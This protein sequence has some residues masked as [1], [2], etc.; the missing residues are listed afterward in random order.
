MLTEDLEGRRRACIAK[1]VHSTRLRSLDPLLE[2]RIW[3]LAPS[4]GV[5]TPV[6]EAGIEKAGLKPADRL[7]QC[8]DPQPYQALLSWL[9]ERVEAA[10]VPIAA[11][12]R[13]RRAAARMSGE[14]G[15]EDR[16][17]AER[18][19]FRRVRTW[20]GDF[21]RVGQRSQVGLPHVD[22]VRLARGR[23]GRSLLQRWRISAPEHK[24]GELDPQF[25]PLGSTPPELMY[26]DPC[27]AA[28]KSADWGV[29]FS[30]VPDVAA[31]SCQ[32]S[33]AFC[34][35]VPA[36]DRV[37]LRV[38]GRAHV[39]RHRQLSAYAGYKGSAASS[40]SC[41]RVRMDFAGR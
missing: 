38:R 17:L 8:Q 37:A 31:G 18:R 3:G 28:D 27:C 7:R 30:V 24:V 12:S 15:I 32:A 4:N 29:E 13:S 21:A 39:S 11:A 20:R 5:A 9:S 6:V 19:R 26:G 2:Q 25:S 10:L 1:A 35:S 33:C 22:W 16:G 34:A 41:R 14:E 23:R 36:L 40:A